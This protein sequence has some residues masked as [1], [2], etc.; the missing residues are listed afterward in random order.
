MNDL[1]FLPAVAGSICVFLL[2]C[3]V[4]R[5]QPPAQDPDQFFRDTVQPILAKQC[6]ECH[7]AEVQE[8]GLRLDS[9]AGLQAGGQ[10][11]K[12]LAVAA[13]RTRAI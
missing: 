13:S 12:K 10:S 6:W 8:N 4:S 2:S 5:G 1:R 9:L 3:A 7:G 11:G